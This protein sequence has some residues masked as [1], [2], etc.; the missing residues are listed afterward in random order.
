MRPEVHQPILGVTINAPEA[1]LACKLNT[2]ANCLKCE[3]GL[4]ILGSH[5]QSLELAEIR[6][7][8]CA[9]ACRRL[10]PHVT[11]QMGC[12][13]VVAVKLF[14]VRASLIAHE[15]ARSDCDNLHHVRKRAC[16]PHPD[17][18][19]LMICGGEAGLCGGID[20]IVLGHD[21]A[22]QA[23]KARSCARLHIRT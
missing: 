1:F 20:G 12:A 16:D 14:L 8:S 3:P 11:D 10:V 5:R 13:E 4:A 6:E 23:A 7:K 18:A 21:S 2:G 15:H 22:P 19:R 9:N 17:L